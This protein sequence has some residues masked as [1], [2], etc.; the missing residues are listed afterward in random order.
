MTSDRTTA[1]RTTGEGSQDEDHALQG[2]SVRETAGP[3]GANHAAILRVAGRCS[4]LAHFD[5]I[6]ARG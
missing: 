4:R 5:S 3:G 2:A 1:G 6:V